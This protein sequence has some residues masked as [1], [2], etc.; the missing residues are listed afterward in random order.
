MYYSGGAC[1]TRR[2]LLGICI[3]AMGIG[4]YTR[5]CYVF[6]QVMH[7]PYTDELE[8]ALSRYCMLACLAPP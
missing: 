2:E 6:T 7:I 5:A 8:T 4:I 1:C 3:D